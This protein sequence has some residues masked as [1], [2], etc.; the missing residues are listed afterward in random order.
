MEA[1]PETSITVKEAAR[2]IGYSVRQ[3]NRFIKAGELEAVRVN[4]SLPRGTRLFLF[5]WQSA[6]QLV[7]S[8]TLA[9]NSS[10]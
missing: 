10:C 4:P 6:A 3:T 8:G 9:A 2:R 1:Q 5:R 7:S